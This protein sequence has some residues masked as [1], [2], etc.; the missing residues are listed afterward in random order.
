M[1]QGKD[2]KRFAA[3]LGV[4]MA[5]GAGGAVAATCTAQSGG[6]PNPQTIAYDLTQGSPGQVQGV[7]CF[8]RANDSNT[9][10]A[11]FS[12]FDF[13]DWKLG[14][15][16][17]DGAGGT[18]RVSFLD[19][20]TDGQDA[21]G[22]WSILNPHGYTSIVLTLN[23][24]NSFSA[25]LLDPTQPLA[26]QWR[27]D[28]PGNSGMGLSHAS[29]Y[30]RGEAGTGNGLAPIPLPAAGWLLLTAIGGLGAAGL[31]RRRKDAA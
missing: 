19:A 14:E 16:V 15:T 5:L 21:P 2:I 13:D 18:G 20:P 8:D 28:G 11:G 22:V 29:I 31:R 17:G 23:R 26:G 4:A 9:I 12:L 24:S 25:F 27:T 3:A 10:L 1:I 30:Y 7:R 6:G